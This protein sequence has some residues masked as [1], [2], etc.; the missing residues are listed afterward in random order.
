L[1]RCCF[2]FRCSAGLDGLIGSPPLSSQVFVAPALARQNPWAHF[3]ASRVDE[4]VPILARRPAALGRTGWVA[5]SITRY[6]I[7]DDN[8]HHASHSTLSLANDKNGNRFVRLTP[9]FTCAW[10]RSE[11]AS[12]GRHC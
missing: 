1:T 6:F 11:Q 12:G 4:G 10:E 5:P 8:A 3:G 2:R 7:G 9:V